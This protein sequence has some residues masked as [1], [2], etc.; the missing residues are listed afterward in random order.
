M[1][2]F[3]KGTTMSN[4]VI[5]FHSG[6]NKTHELQALSS[7]SAASRMPTLAARRLIQAYRFSPETA[8]VVATL[9]GFADE[10]A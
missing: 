9:A 2:E 5:Y 10:A 7:Q 8:Q 4:Q 6:R 1:H 3:C